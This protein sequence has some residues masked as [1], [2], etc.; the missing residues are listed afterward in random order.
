MR[1][2][3]WMLLCITFNF[4]SWNSSKNAKIFVDIGVFGSIPKVSEKHKCYDVGLRHATPGTSEVFIFQKAPLGDKGQL[5][6]CTSDCTGKAKLDNKRGY[7]GR[8]GFYKQVDK[9]YAVGLEGYYESYNIE[10]QDNGYKFQCT[11][12]DCAK[13]ITYDGQKIVTKVESGET[14][15]T[16][17][18]AKELED[19]CSNVFNSKRFFDPSKAF[20]KSKRVQMGALVA[21]KMYTNTG[22]SYLKLAAGIGALK[23]KIPVAQKHKAC[24]CGTTHDEGC[25]NDF[26]AQHQYKIEDVSAKKGLVWGVSVGTKISQNIFMG[27]D[28]MS[29]RNKN[30]ENTETY[31]NNKF[32]VS[33]SMELGK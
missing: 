19:T 8:F 17:E 16:T 6:T 33:L 2:Y 27:L 26:D 9:F 21:V 18:E 5:H 11:H 10:Y 22:G 1:E 13:Y 20:K 28:F 30:K 32:G 31:V 23:R 25:P 29:Q 14:T 24:S 3:A 15:Y 7:G 4:F 12:D